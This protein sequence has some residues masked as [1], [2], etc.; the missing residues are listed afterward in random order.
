MRGIQI[1]CDYLNFNDPPED[2]FNLLELIVDSYEQEKIE[3]VQQKRKLTHLITNIVDKM[4]RTTASPLPLYNFIAFLID[5]YPH[6][7]DDVL[8][9][10]N[11]IGLELTE[12]DS[13]TVKGHALLGVIK[14]CKE[15]NATGRNHVEMGNGGDRTKI[16]PRIVAFMHKIRQTGKN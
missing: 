16:L 14:S 6:K 9:R 13:E 5:K 7:Y 3:D 15:N 11:Q 8:E 2:I 4:A 12:V 10:I 1:L